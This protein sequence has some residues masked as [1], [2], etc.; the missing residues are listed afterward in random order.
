M[1]VCSLQLLA[2]VCPAPACRASIKNN[3]FATN[4]KCNQEQHFPIVSGSSCM[5]EIHMAEKNVRCLR[6]GSFYCRH[7]L[8]EVNGFICFPYHHKIEITL[9]E[10]IS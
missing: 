5:T 6:L 1:H 2:D 8:E 7:A 9:K 4:R 10:K 3:V